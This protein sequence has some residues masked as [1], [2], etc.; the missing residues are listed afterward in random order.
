MRSKRIL[1][2]NYDMDDE[3]QVFAHQ[4]EVVR[5][6][7]KE[8]QDVFVLTAH[9]GHKSEVPLNVKI[10]STKWLV[11]RN[12]RNVTVFYILFF[13]ILFNEQID[14]VFSHMTEIQ[15]A[16]AA[17]ILKILNIPHVT[18]YAHAKRSKFLVW[19]HLFVDRLVTSTAGSCPIQSEKVHCIGQAIDKDSFFASV[20]KDFSKKLFVHVGRIDKSKNLDTIINL[21]IK[22]RSIYPDIEL[23]LIGRPSVGN[24]SDYLHKLSELASLHSFIH[25]SPPVARK[26][27]PDLLNGNDVF[28]HAFQGSLDKTLIEATLAGLPVITINNE[29]LNE[30]GTW[31]QRNTSIDLDNEFSAFMSS[32]NDQIEKLC[33][34]RQQIAITKHS[35]DQWQTQLLRIFDDLMSS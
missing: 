22:K 8:F 16:L 17:P 21:L 30:F 28:I 3:S 26:N 31:S 9:K 19:N 2:F 15:S 25:I 23:N 20:K 5:K 13:K 34:T 27:L 4:I 18:W 10:I 24:K 33:K 7:A 29:Y 12:L 35:F 11:N 14:L 1:V 32:P 6:L